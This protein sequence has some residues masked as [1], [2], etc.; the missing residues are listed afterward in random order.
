MIRRLFLMRS[1]VL[2]FCAALSA[3]GAA[4]PPKPAQPALW[5]L[6]DADTTIYLFG[7][8]HL[9]PRDLNWQSPMIDA[10]IR[11]SDALVLETVLDADPTKTSAILTGLGVSPGLPPL[12]DRVPAEKRA[13]LARIV[14]ESGIPITVLDG[15]E[16]WAAAL[17][18]ASTSLGDLNARA[19]D[20]AEAVLSAR[21]AKMRKPVSGLETPAQ[22]LGYFDR[23]PEAA[24]RTFLASVADDDSNARAEFDA[25]VAAWGAGDVKR[26]E[27]TFDDELKL[28]PEL[29]DA[30]LRQRNTRWT[31]WI[32]GRMAQPGTVFVAVGAGHLAGPDSVA[33]MLSAKG[34]KVT[35]V[36]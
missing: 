27:L 18:L 25:M 36:Q 2:P 30:L 1:L 28:S 7:T 20:G 3:C 10:A 22:Q 29:A 14:K 33:A 21:F 12:L 24:Q 26:I 8:I 5:R 13:S 19:E 6:A 31:Q 11:A 4:Q 35:R 23:L 34:M 9:L 16:T 17:T 15:F 32:A